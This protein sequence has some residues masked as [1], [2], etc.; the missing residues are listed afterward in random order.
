MAHLDSNEAKYLQ[1]AF[2]VSQYLPET[3]KLNLA[4]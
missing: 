3:R 2:D 1:G 4:Q